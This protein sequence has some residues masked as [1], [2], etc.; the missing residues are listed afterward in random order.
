MIVQVTSTGG[1][2]SNNQFN[3]QIPGGGVGSHY[4]GCARQF[5]G[6]YSWGAQYGGVNQRSDCANLPAALQSGCHWRFDWFRNAQNPR[7]IF[8]QVVCPSVLT[9]KTQCVRQ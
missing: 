9:A 7:I 2:F 6:S 1:G 4:Q 3:L 5:L 8:Q